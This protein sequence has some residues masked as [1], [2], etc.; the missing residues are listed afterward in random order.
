MTTLY[1]KY[2]PQKISELDLKD[3]RELLSKIIAKGDIPHAFL[4]EGPRGSGKTSAARIMAKVLNCE[5]LSKDNEPC[6]VC[7]QCVSITKGTNID[8]IE[9][10]AA[11]HRGIDDIRLIKDSVKLAP[12][13]ANK[14]VYII[15]EAH[16]L[17]TE[18][19]NA[20]LKTLE[21]PP[22]H[23]VFIL[24]TTNP[25]KLIDTI[26]SRTVRVVFKKAK[27]LEIV[28][29]LEVVLEKEKKKYNAAVLELVSKSVDGSFR[30]AKKLL[31]E[32]LIKDAVDDLDKAQEYILGKSEFD[33]DKLFEVLYAKDLKA[34]IDLLNRAEN[35]SVSVKTV[36]SQ[37]VGK[38]KSLLFSVTGFQND[39]TNKFEKEEVYR[40]TDIF[41]KFW[42][43]Y[44]NDI[45]EYL[46][47]YLAVV[48]WCGGNINN[49]DNKDNI[50]DNEDIINSNN[51]SKTNLSGGEKKDEQVIKKSVDFGSVA[52]T[53]KK[54]SD[55]IWKEV[56]V[57]VRCKNTSTE[58]LLRASRPVDFDGKRLMLGVF[59]KF[60]KEKLETISH[61][62]CLE[63]TLKD[64]VG[65]DV[66]VE[67]FLAEQ[68]FK[69]TEE[70]A[71]N[72]TGVSNDSK[73]GDTNSAQV[74][75]TDVVSSD[76]EKLAD[77]VFG[78]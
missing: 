60:H 34:G 16:M 5:H 68:P 33:V 66:K 10:D 23:V 73:N 69:K 27:A 46:P 45:S 74:I 70:T 19:S 22:D 55:D 29:S 14:K 61:R 77:E 18:A 31:E 42:K 12:A 36:M 65:E 41:I 71:L 53:G 47:L 28:K 43:K 32:L 64:V 72:D 58:A 56:L 48:K 59:Y 40:L 37:I 75:L 20:L 8:V 50:K 67:C 11:S 4:F 30:D 39:S 13:R 35:A 54:I 76:I 9:L 24:A 15:D 38:L 25:E 44:Q 6:N 57:K 78:N 62:S 52:L 26:K 49:A 2:R 3:V 51:N 17:T 1:L 21:E 63:E 7:D